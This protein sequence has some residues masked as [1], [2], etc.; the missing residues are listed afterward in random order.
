MAYTH[1]RTM[2]STNFITPAQLKKIHVIL[3]ELGLMACKEKIISDCT[4]GRTASCRELTRHEAKTLIGVL[5]NMDDRHR[6]INAILYLAYNMEM[7]YGTSPEDKKMNVAKLDA[8]CKSR[9]SVKKALYLQNVTE[10]K[11]THRQFESIYR[12]HMIKKGVELRIKSLREAFQAAISEE[13]Y[14][15]CMKIQLELELLT[16]KHE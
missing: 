7:I 9:G 16:K 2:N 3:N 12:R 5:C 4:D 14:E 8:F 15:D 11:K 13:K 1:N 6:H 10:L